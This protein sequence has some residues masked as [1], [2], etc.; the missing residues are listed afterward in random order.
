MRPVDFLKIDTENIRDTFFPNLPPE[1]SAPILTLINRLEEFCTLDPIRKEILVN[2]KRVEEGL[3]IALP[4]PFSTTYRNNLIQAIETQIHIKKA[5]N[6]MTE[7][8]EAQTLLHEEF[9]QSPTKRCHPQPQKLQAWSSSLNAIPQQYRPLT[10]LITKTKNSIRDISASHPLPKPALADPEPLTQPCVALQNIHPTF[11]PI[12]EALE[13]AI[14]KL[15]ITPKTPLLLLIKLLT[16]GMPT[17]LIDIRKQ[18]KHAA[19]KNIQNGKESICK[20]S[21]SLENPLKQNPYLKT[22]TGKSRLYPLAIK[23]L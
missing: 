15:E 8:L 12:T 20:G 4:Y 17:N 23:E 22:P 9:K 5:L 1:H 11:I 21:H 18:L 10:L 6:I 14:R 19:E 3:K 2:K 16:L 7:V 13:K